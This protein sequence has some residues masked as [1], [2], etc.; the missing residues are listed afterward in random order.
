MTVHKLLKDY[1][2][3]VSSDFNE[4]DMPED[5]RRVFEATKSFEQLCRYFHVEN[6]YYEWPLQDRAKR[7]SAPSI[8]HLC[9]SLLFVNTKWKP[10]T[11]SDIGDFLPEHPKY[12]LVCVQYTDKISTKKLNLGVRELGNNSQSVKSFNM[13]LAPEQKALEYTGFGNNSV[14]PFGMLQNIPIIVTKKIAELNPPLLYLGMG[15]VDWKLSV[16]VE[17]LL[18]NPNAHVMD[19]S[20]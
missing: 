7:M 6:D 16:P 8:D 14:S 5:T 1:L 9:K 11:D 18:D 12:V 13:R 20:E 17:R 19:L 4:K 3:S 15:H 2:Q 10:R